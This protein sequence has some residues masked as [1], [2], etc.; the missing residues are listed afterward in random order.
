MTKSVSSCFALIIFVNLIFAINPGEIS[1]TAQFLIFD[2]F[3][4]INQQDRLFNDEIVIIDI[5]EQAVE[6]L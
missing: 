2:T 4:R 1:D 3:Q 5:D 6:N